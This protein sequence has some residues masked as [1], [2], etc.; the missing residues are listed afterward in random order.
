MCKVTLVTLK[1]HKN[2][3]IVGYCLVFV[4]KQSKF[5]KQKVG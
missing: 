4:L 1:V 3:D 5:K 2:M